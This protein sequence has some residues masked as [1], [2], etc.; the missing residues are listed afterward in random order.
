VTRVPTDQEREIRIRELQA[1]L[2]VLRHSSS[3][4]SGQRVAH[5]VRELEELGER[6][7]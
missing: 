2:A 4:E 5:I 1:E 3:K 6:K 7:P